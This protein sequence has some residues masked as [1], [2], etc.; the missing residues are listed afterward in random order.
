MDLMSVAYVL[1]GLGIVLM[2]MEMF[3][4]TGGICFL[5]SLAC[6][7]GGVAIS[8]IYGDSQTGIITLLVVFVAVPLVMVGW[9]RIWPESMMGKRLIPKDDED[10]SVA[11][12][13]GN[14]Q[15]EELRGRIGKTVS[16]LRPSGIVEFDGKRVDCITE[17]MMVEPD[18]WVRCIDV[19][20]GRVLVREIEKPNL[21][22]LESTNFG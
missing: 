17:G 15:L 3:L 10:T 9:F 20:A 13:P 5:L 14:V 11:N 6:F 7:M 1:I 16:A 21:Q 18:R 8:F 2:L 12:M 19:R 4:P 22:D